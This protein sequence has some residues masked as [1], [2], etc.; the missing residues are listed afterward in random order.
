M[1]SF[2]TFL[3]LC[4]QSG[5]SQAP[6]QKGPSKPLKFGALDGEAHTRSSTTHV[7]T[8]SLRGL[9]GPQRCKRPTLVAVDHLAEEEDFFAGFAIEDDDDDDLAPPKPTKPADPKTKPPLPSSGRG[10]SSCFHQVDSALAACACRERAVTMR[11]T[12]A[13]PCLAA[14]ARTCVALRRGSL[15]CVAYCAS[16]CGCLLC[17]CAARMVLS[18][19]EDDDIAPTGPAAQPLR[20]APSPLQ[21]IHDDAPPEPVPQLTPPAADMPDA[22]DAT[23]QPDAVMEQPAAP[24]DIT[25]D[26]GAADATTPPEPQPAP[27]AAN[28]AH[29]PVE[30]HPAATA[31]AALVVAVQNATHDH[32]TPLTTLTAQPTGEAAAPAAAGP[33]FV[34]EATAVGGAQ[35]NGQALLPPDAGASP[36]C[37]ATTNVAAP[38]AVPVPM[39]ITAGA[40]ATP[41]AGSPAVPAKRKS[42]STDAPDPADAHSDKAAR[43]HVLAS[44]STSR[45]TLLAD[46]AA[47]AGAAATATA[48][49][50]PVAPPPAQPPAQLLG[51]QPSGVAVAAGAAPKAPAEPAAPVLG[52][53]P[54][55]TLGTTQASAKTPLLQPM[56]VLGGGTS[57]LIGGGVGAKL[58]PKLPALTLGLAAPAKPASVTATTNAPSPLP[59]A[60]ARPTTPPTVPAAAGSP[61]A[62]ERAVRAASSAAAGG[63][64]NVLASAVAS[65]AAMKATVAA[66][67]SPRATPAT[68]AL[69]SPRASPATQPTPHGQQVSPMPPAA[70]LAAL[71]ASPAQAA[72]AASPVPGAGNHA[73]AGVALLRASPTAQAVPPRRPASPAAKAAA[74]SGPAVPAAVDPA[75]GGTG[76]QDA[77]HAAAGAAQ[78]ARVALLLSGD[79]TMADRPD[80]RPAAPSPAASPAARA[81][82]AS[83]ASLT[84]SALTETA[85]AGRNTDPLQVPRPPATHAA[86][87]APATPSTAAQRL[88]GDVD[89][90][91]PAAVTPRSVIAAAD[92]TMGVGALME[93]DG[94]D[95]NREFPA[96]LLD[97]SNCMHKLETVSLAALHIHVLLHTHAFYS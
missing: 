3:T 94:D 63:Q 61:S 17:L 5:G 6:S 33:P 59:A 70:A 87:P 14:R 24:A 19:N 64:V 27:V 7:A 12:T 38:A 97:R 66:A 89:M 57:V 79:V 9:T 86:T 53:T 10:M 23:E 11:R 31:S 32:A 35:A 28:T 8:H 18:D 54:N 49:A 83:A 34:C 72:G 26:T 77:A 41:A 55:P 43:T 71:G 44:P 42:T 91:A 67:E 58:L 16:P 25:Q 13:H 29:E 73:R 2:C 96:A 40:A 45:A 85:A 75:A 52:I 95:D 82:A 22:S 68:L 62:A 50:L 36:A 90:A 20:P 60:L 48:P 39:G 4:R 51:L 74:A 92:V 30:T 15:A 56:T 47:G 76:Q 21:T 80:A 37:Q 69:A 46:P 81:P 1:L 93:P 78:R 84:G 65:P 88:A